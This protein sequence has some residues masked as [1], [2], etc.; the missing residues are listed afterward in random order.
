MVDMFKLHH[1]GVLV[2]DIGGETANFT[3]ILG[4]TAESDIIE[5]KTQTALVRFLRQPGAAFWVELISPN[6]DGSKLGKALKWGG[7][8]HHFC[9][10]VPDIEKACIGLRNDG[11]MMI[12]EP[13]A[14]AAFPGRKIAWFIGRNRVLIELLEAREGVLSLFSITRHEGC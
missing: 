9:Y 11:M 1:V 8:L 14:A 7:G 10:E 13:V 5:D 3:G 6:G 2:K 4:Y 12:A